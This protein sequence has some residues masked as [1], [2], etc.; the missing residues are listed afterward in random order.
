MEGL[1]IWAGIPGL[2]TI[3]FTSFVLLLTR[4]YKRCPSNRVLVIYGK[5]GTGESARNYFP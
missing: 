5:V 1:L 2:A 3:V 4:R